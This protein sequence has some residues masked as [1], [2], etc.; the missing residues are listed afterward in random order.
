MR[1][2][3][4]SEELRP[5]RQ[6]VLNSNSAVAVQALV[7]QAEKRLKLVHSRMKDTTR[8]AEMEAGRMA[9]AVDRFRAEAETLWPRLKVDVKEYREDRIVQV[10]AWVKGEKGPCLVIFEPRAGFPSIELQAQLGLIG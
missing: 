5:Q 8:Q 6:A 3:L 2:L 9:I 1:E 10:I 7:T 4:Q